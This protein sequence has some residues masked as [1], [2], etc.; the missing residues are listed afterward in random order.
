MVWHMPSRLDLIGSA[1]ACQ[2]LGIER[3]T[4][5]RWVQMRWLKPAGKLPGPNG[6]YLYRRPDIEA[7]AAKRAAE[8][9]A[10]ASAVAGT[11]G[12]VA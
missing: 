3:S 6:A 1:E 7:L 8:T 4:L 10:E 12:D 5:V 11:N 9:A 2:I